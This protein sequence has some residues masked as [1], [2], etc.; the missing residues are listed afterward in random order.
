MVKLLQG[1]G[2]E[3]EDSENRSFSLPERFL[4][5]D[6]HCKVHVSCHYNG[7]AADTLVEAGAEWVPMAANGN[8]NGTGNGNGAGT[9]QAQQVD[10]AALNG[11]EPCLEPG[12]EG[13]QAAAQ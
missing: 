7:K 9:A 3:W 1:G 6:C 10:V 12:A 8:G 4:Q 11:T 13:G 5:L 2:V